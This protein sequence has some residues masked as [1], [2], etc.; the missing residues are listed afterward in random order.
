MSSKSA[1]LVG[2]AVL[3]AVLM[4]M[5]AIAIPLAICLLIADYRSL[6]L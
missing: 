4:P 1:V 5:P 6:K 3:V 2:K